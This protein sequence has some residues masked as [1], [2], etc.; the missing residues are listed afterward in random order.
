[1]AY[2]TQA[3]I[4]R[5]IDPRELV[6][7]ADHDDDGSADAAVVT[8]A[9]GDAQ[10]DIDSYLQTRYSVPVSPVPAAVTRTS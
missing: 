7:L 4:V 1:M 8:Q 6:R 3:D 5:R 9:I 2:C 10:G